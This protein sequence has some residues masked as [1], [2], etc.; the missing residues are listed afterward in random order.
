MN[1]RKYVLF[2][3]VTL[4]LA[5]TLYSNLVA[6]PKLR[7]QLL[8]K[9]RYSIATIQNIWKVRKG[10][11]MVSYS[12]SVDGKKYNCSGQGFIQKSLNAF[13]SHSINQKRYVVYLAENPFKNSILPLCIPPDTIQ[14][15]K[16]GWNKLPTGSIEFVIP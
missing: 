14:C 6:E 7:N 3:L 11:T 13:S 8:I 5:Y 9:G 2:L 12:F 4:I 16:N 15:P 1:I 10:G